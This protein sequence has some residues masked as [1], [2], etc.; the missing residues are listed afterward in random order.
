L[1]N[2]RILGHLLSYAPND[3]AVA[4]LTKAIVSEGNQ[5]VNP[6]ALSELGDFYKN[7]FLRAFRRFKCRT[8]HASTHPSRPSFEYTKE[9][10]ARILQEY[11][12]DHYHARTLAMLRDGH[13][14]M[15]THR[16]DVHY[17]RSVYAHTGKGGSESVSAL[18]CA[19]IFSESTNTNLQNA[20][21]H[22]YATTAW[23]VLE[24]FG[25]PAI[26]KDL[27]GANV[28]SLVNILTLDHTLTQRECLG[29]IE[30][31]VTFKSCLP[32]AP[33]PSAKYLQIHA[34]CCKVAHLSGASGL[35]DR[36]EEEMDYDPDPATVPA[37][38]KALEAHLEHITLV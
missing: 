13:R 31:Y 10:I 2:V 9:Q 36:M 21:K 33:L 29:I 37:F 3:T 6:E 11:P 23:A 26:V 24:Q 17:H 32:G 25:Y 1:I 38:A 19:H 34:A 22:K 15:L 14:C 30:E 4:G 27:A 18:E 7:H 12:R 28:H 16:T 5:E 8:P 35:F 20:A